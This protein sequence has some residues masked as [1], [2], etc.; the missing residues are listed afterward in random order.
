MSLLRYTG[1]L[2]WGR[3][4]MDSACVHDRGGRQAKPTDFD[5]TLRK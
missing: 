4:C 1:L 5:E 3:H 2:R